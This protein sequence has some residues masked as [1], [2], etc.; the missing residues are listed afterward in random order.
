MIRRGLINQRIVCGIYFSTPNYSTHIYFN[1]PHGKDQKEKRQEQLRKPVQTRFSDLI[2]IPKTIQL[3]PR[4]G[5]STEG[6]DRVVKWALIFNFADTI[7][8]FGAAYMTGSKSLF[9]EGVHSLMDTVNQIILYVGIKYSAKNADLNFPYG[10]GN[11]RYVTSLISGCGILSFGCGLS[12]YHGV[13]G[14]LH[15]TDLEPLKH[16]MLWECHYFSKETH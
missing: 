16:S 10:Y 12:I 11:A 14:L 7:S 5:R 4:R 13:T 15:P 8:K 9:A 3:P 6:A 2:A 1:S